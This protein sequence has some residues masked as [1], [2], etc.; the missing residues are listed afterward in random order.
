MVKVADFGLA[1]VYEASPLSGL[2]LSGSAGGTPPFM[3]PEQ[4][5]DLRS[6]QPPADQYAAAGTTCTP[7]RSG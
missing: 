2:T 3:P 1:R 5:R 7:P 4:V 6:V